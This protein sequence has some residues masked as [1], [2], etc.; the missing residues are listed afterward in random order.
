MRNLH[1]SAVFVRPFMILPAEANEVT[2]ERQ[3][4]KK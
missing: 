2:Y 3:E 1:N 4:R